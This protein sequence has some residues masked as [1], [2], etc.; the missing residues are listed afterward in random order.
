MRSGAYSRSRR[1]VACGTE[2]RGVMT[3]R[4]R[5]A[6]SRDITGI[7]TDDNGNDREI[8]RLGLIWFYVDEEVAPGTDGADDHEGHWYLRGSGI[9]MPE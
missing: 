2:G 9:A 6:I 8:V 3:D 4:P 5:D 1:W 7:V